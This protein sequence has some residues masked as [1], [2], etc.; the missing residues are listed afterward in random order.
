MFHRPDS[1][2]HE[3]TDV[4]TD[5]PHS[6]VLHALLHRLCEAHAGTLDDCLLE[7]PWQAYASRIDHRIQRLRT[8]YPRSWLTKIREEL[9]SFKAEELEGVVVGC[10][11]ILR[12]LDTHHRSLRTQAKLRQGF[13]LPARLGGGR[14]V[15]LP[16]PENA[17]AEAVPRKKRL[18]RERRHLKHEVREILDLWWHLVNLDRS[19]ETPRFLDLDA[20]AVGRLQSRW[21]SDGDLSIALAAPF[22]D[23]DF[24]F[25]ADPNRCHDHKG[26]PY[27][28][29]GLK[30]VHL[31]EARSI[32]DRLLESCAE[33]RVDVL[34]FPE[35]TLD[36]D[37]LGHLQSR[38]K[39]GDSSRQPALVIAG[40]FHL[41]SE[42]RW[43][44]RCHVLDGRGRLL[45]TQDKCKPFEIPAEQA[46]HMPELCGKL[47][48]DDRGGFEDVRCSTE[49]VIA[50]FPLGRLATP[51][52]LDFCGKEL[53]E[54][55]I[56][57]R[58]NLLLVP[59]MTPR[60]KP[61]VESAR[62]FGTDCRG[63]V[64]VVNSAW[65]LRQLGTFDEAGLYLGYV[66]SKGNLG[67]GA[68]VSEDLMVFSVRV[69][70]GGA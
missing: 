51:I 63:S 32:V 66:P 59:A 45:F 61:F 70:L 50:D 68:K 21:E 47:G 11:A 34:C 1:F 60:M 44:N 14:A 56:E 31:K 46:R 64:F 8:S 53:R 62:D 69:L 6:V 20:R 22:A 42:L 25:H 19:A 39:S 24:D 55:F 23:L 13:D 16:P 54:L 48:I 4:A 67:R 26:I 52:C 65:L 28:F 15:L 35:L 49:V 57:S 9:A 40:S 33:H 3:L 41:T 10:S 2:L 58:T 27:R 43:V 30:S 5:F 29:V 17:I 12:V 7:E 18:T 36:N 37:L 38:L